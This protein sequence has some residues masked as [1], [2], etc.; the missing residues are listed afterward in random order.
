MV[1]FSGRS[2]TISRAAVPRRPNRNMWH[3]NEGGDSSAGRGAGGG[4]AVM[5]I[6][7]SRG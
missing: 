5:G 3:N 6:R 4:Q 1:E 2:F 7:E